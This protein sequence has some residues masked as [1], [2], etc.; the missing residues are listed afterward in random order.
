M[1]YTSDDMTSSQDAISNWTVLHSIAYM[2]ASNNTTSGDS[3]TADEIDNLRYG[4]IT[5]IIFTIAYCMISII[6]VVGN[7]AVFIVVTK[8]PQMRTLTNKLI[9]NLAIADLLVNVVCVP[10]TLVSNLYPEWTLGTFICK[11]VSYMQGVSVSASVNTLMAISIER[12]IA[13]SCPY[14]SI[15]SRQYKVAVTMIWLIA[16]SVNLPWL[17]VFQLE[18]IESGSNRKVCIELWPS[19]FS[20]NVY[21]VLAN[22]ILCYLA[23][24]SVIT[25]CYV[26]IWRSVAHRSIPGEY[27]GYK[28]TRDSINKSR[29]K[30][31]KMVFVVII[32][33]ALSWLPL[34]CIFC[35]VKFWEEMLYDEQ[36]QVKEVIYFLVPIAQ[37]LGASNSSI[38]PI[39]YCYMN[40]KFRIS[41]MNLMMRCSFRF[42]D[43]IA[44]HQARSDGN[45]K[46]YKFNNSGR[47]LS[48][49]FSGTSRNEYGSKV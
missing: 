3:T 2:S 20:E 44:M 27:L 31:T 46:V 7:V 35:I 10:F 14:V 40:K 13:I 48:V 26:I 23:P 5:S 38:N 36:G 47:T 25:F 29:L 18:P 16:L 32:T 45:Y 15:T 9:G 8:S 39:L 34:Y 11:T 37:W 12:C 24:L 49:R 19:T 28:S 21:F 41:F 6:G 17:Y 4:M 30:V 1:A 22:L 42:Q 43:D 33:F